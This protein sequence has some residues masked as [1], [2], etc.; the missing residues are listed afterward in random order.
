MQILSSDANFSK[1]VTQISQKDTAQ[2][3]ELTEKL[4]VGQFIRVEVAIAWKQRIC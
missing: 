1:D 2:K 4:C 3:L